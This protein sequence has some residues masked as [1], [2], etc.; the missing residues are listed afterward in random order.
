MFDLEGLQRSLNQIRMGPNQWIWFSE[1]THFIRI[2]MTIVIVPFLRPQIRYRK[3]KVPSKQTPTFSR[4]SGVKDL[5]NGSAIAATLHFYCPQLLPLEGKTMPGQS[6]WWIWGVK[7]W[8]VELLWADVCLKD[9]MSVADSLYNLQLIRDFCEEHLNNCCPLVL[10]DLLYA[11]PILRVRYTHTNIS[12]KSF[13]EISPL[14][15]SVRVFQRPLVWPSQQ[16]WF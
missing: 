14:P 4:V 10:E 3:D 15:N 1:S 5:S 8:H 6:S 12:Y 7:P 16:P 13:P 2:N 11:P 9:T